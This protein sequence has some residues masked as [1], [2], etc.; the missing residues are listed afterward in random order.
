M[1]PLLHPWSKLHL[2]TLLLVGC[3]V[4]F[5]S[6]LF[7]IF[8]FISESTL[9]CVCVCAGTHHIW[10]GFGMDDLICFIRRIRKFLFSKLGN[11]LI[12]FALF[13][14]YMFGITVCDC[15]CLLLL[16]LGL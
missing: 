4:L 3:V 7:R 15:Q 12:L 13:T 9:L 10:S 6:V 1:E 11:N 14:L 2:L 8:V 5:A 16:E